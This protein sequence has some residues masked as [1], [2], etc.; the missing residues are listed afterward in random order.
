MGMQ[1]V[2]CSSLTALGLAGWWLAVRHAGVAKVQQ[3]DDPVMQGWPRPAGHRGLGRSSPPGGQVQQLGMQLG[4]HLPLWGQILR[5]GP[6]GRGR[7]VQALLQCIRD[8]QGL[9]RARQ[10]GPSLGGL[11]GGGSS[12]RCRR[13]MAGDLQPSCRCVG[14]FQHDLPQRAARPREG[15]R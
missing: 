7:C 13:R 1:L 3:A 8:W 5:R 14:A 9:G 6:R 2:S 15:R 10:P 11:V 12:C 4:G